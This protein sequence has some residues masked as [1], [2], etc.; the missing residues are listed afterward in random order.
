M[1]AQAMATESSFNFFAVKGGEL[2]NMYVGETERSIRNLFRRAQEAS[3]SIVFFDEID[4]IAGSRPGSGSGST[5]GGVQALTTLLTEMAGFERKGDV[6][7]LAAT[8]KPDALD[9]ALLRPGRF[10]QLIY[11][12]LPDEGAR[13]TILAK[14]ARQLQFPV[15][16]GPR[17]EG[18]GQGLAKAGLDLDALARELEGY[19]GAEVASVCDRAFMGVE[20]EAEYD[21]MEVLR[22]AIRSTPKLVTQEM[23]NH[24]ARWHAS[25]QT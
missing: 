22:A 12:P 11:V 8:N 4:A 23:L 21:A 13:R 15:S 10:D 14:K 9:P 6:F 1:T 16:S 17:G 18:E 2:L 19:S 3:P 5:A 20:A 24:F 7:V 25:V